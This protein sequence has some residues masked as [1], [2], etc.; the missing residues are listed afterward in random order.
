MSQKG[1]IKLSIMILIG[2]ICL[3][4]IYFI[5]TICPI[6]QFK[7]NAV[8]ELGSCFNLKN[9][10]SKSGLHCY[11]EKSSA[12][13]I[14]MPPLPERFKNIAP[15]LPV[16]DDENARIILE[17]IKTKIANVNTL[18][19]IAAK[20]FDPIFFSK[21]QYLKW[22][23]TTEAKLIKK[24]GYY[25]NIQDLEIDMN[26]NVPSEIRNLMRTKIRDEMHKKIRKIVRPHMQK[27][28]P[29]KI[30]YFLEKIT[31][32]GKPL[33]S[34]NEMKMIRKYIRA[35]NHIKM[36]ALIS[37]NIHPLIPNIVGTYVQKTII[38]IETQRLI[39]KYLK[40]K[41]P[42]KHKNSKDN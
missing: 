42:G 8:S 4:A 29:I 11:P 26:D 22:F 13:T 3:T 34:E 15:R 36:R 28:M 24:D 16:I 7:Q 20:T 35:K 25:K 17:K 18:S 19:Q 33:P 6:N 40:E 14:T 41:Y 37:E 21:E 23:E 39:H 2:G 5:I 12:E 9:S 31:E 27:I 1:K 38:T 10:K 30:K 32:G